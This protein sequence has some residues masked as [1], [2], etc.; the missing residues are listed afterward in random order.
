MTAFLLR[1]WVIMLSLLIY[2]NITGWAQDG[3]YKISGHVI[4]SDHE[5]LPKAH[6]KFNDEQIFVTDEHGDFTV[7]GLGNGQY[8]IEIFYIGFDTLRTQVTI[9]NSSKHLDFVLN[10]ADQQLK[11]VTVIGDHFKTGRLEQSQTIKTVDQDFIQNQNAGTLVN[12]VEK[13]PGV[14]AIN[15]GVGIAKPVIRGMSFNRVIVMDKG[16]K[17]EGQQW[18]AD[19]GLEIDQYD[20]ERLEIIKGPSSLLYGSDGL[21]G[22]IRIL[23]PTIPSEDHLSGSFFTTYKNNNQLIGTSTGLHGKKNGKFFRFRFSTQDFGDYS[24]PADNFTYN[25]FVLSINE[26]RLKNT[27]GR[28]RNFSVSL[29]MDEKWGSTSVT[30]SNFHQQAGL[31][32]GATGIPR[33]YLLEDDGDRRNIVLPHQETNHFKVISNTSI[34]LGNSWLEMD[35]GYQFNDRKEMGEPHAHGYQPTP[36]GNLALGLKLETYSANIRF[37]NQYSDQLLGVYGF[38]GQWQENRFEGFEFLLPAFRS[39]NA[40]VFAYHEYSLSHVFTMNA[41]IRFDH[42]RHD[43]DEHITP[44]FSTPEEGDSVL[45]NADIN[46]QFNDFS[47]ALGFSYYPNIHFNTKLNIGTSFRMPDAV[48]L[49]S[50]GIHHGT[51]RHERGDS[52]L[53]SERGIQVDWN[54]T[55]KKNGWYALF[56]PYFGYYY[57]YIYLGPQAEFSD[58][59]GGG[60]LYKYAQND[61][62]FTGFETDLEYTIEESWVIRSA[63]EYVW[64]RNMD[65]QLPLPFTPPF[66]ILGELEYSFDWES[67]RI[68]NPFVLLNVHH[69]A[70]QNRVDRN[71]NETPGYNL[72]AVKAGA[73]IRIFDQLTEFRVSINNLFNTKYLNHLSRYRLLNLPEQGRNIVFSLEIPFYIN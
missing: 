9:Q 20:P 60:Q 14:S 69:Y 66:S 22:A 63:A 59:P 7:S 17:Q 58:L 44:D 10:Y 67:K 23:P 41:G 11:E 28:E 3:P 57:N 38:Q 73:N 61:A 2:I 19:H 26:N 68:S 56:T 45:R 5:I 24:V 43:I 52:T 64:N 15:T 40:G 34:T 50:D 37:N 27:A 4:S 1:G 55:Y 18:G 53:T 42:G 65:A 54:L 48:E 12:S 16:I 29:G 32:P 35:L 33:E 8:K 62:I 36:D 71:E 30:I 21:G 46:K 70:S 25:S 51:F 6:I 13:L 49:S 31:F 39:A 47:A 72:V